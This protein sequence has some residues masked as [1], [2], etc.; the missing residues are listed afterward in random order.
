[1]T[2]ADDKGPAWRYL[3]PLLIVAGIVAYLVAVTAFIT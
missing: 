1:M 2:P 3:P